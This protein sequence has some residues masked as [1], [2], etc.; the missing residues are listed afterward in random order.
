ML[1]AHIVIQVGKEG[2]YSAKGCREMS[3][4]SGNEFCAGIWMYD[5]DGWS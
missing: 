1:G 2:G 4:I 5:L 3:D